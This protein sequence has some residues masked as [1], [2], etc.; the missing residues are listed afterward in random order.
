MSAVQNQQTG[1]S[2]LLFISAEPFDSLT[3]EEKNL[4]AITEHARS[5]SSEV[6]QSGSDVQLAR[7]RIKRYVKRN[8]RTFSISFRYL[9]SL[10][11]KTV[12]G[13][14]GRD[15]IHELAQTRG[16]V[17][18]LVKLD[19]NNGYESYTC[20]IN[21]YSE[22]LLRRDLENACSYYDI[23]IGLEEQ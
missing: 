1:L 12:D 4:C 5:F 18:L 19:P 17:Y 3:T 8:K 15:S 21:S 7:G 2:N 20:Y 10:S 6:Q 16:L 22:S 14:G 11:D 9:P 13:R 23:N